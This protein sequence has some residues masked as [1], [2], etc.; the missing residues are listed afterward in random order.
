MSSTKVWVPSGL[1]TTRA[2]RTLS[3]PYLASLRWTIWAASGGWGGWKLSGG[4]GARGDK[5]GRRVE[6]AVGAQEVRSREQVQQSV[7]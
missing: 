6:G 1:R 2:T 7:C 3:L 4:G 5:T